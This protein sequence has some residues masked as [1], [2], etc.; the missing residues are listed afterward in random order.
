MNSAYT[1]PITAINN[2]TDKA[3]N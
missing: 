3:T 1:N 2:L